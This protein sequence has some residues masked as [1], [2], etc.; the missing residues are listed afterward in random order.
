MKD[1]ESAF[2]LALNR[3]PQLGCIKQRQ[4]LHSLSSASQVFSADTPTLKACGLTAQQIAYIRQPDWRRVEADLAWLERPEHHLLTINDTAYPTLLK[5]IAD[6]PIIL[7]AQGLLEVLQTIQVG[8]IGSRNPNAG[9]RRI[10]EQF[11]RELAQAGATI[12]SGLALGIDTCSHQGALQAKGYTVAVAGN[13]LDLVYPARNKI[14][15]ENIAENGVLISEFPPGTKPI[16]ANFPRRNR[17]ISGISTGVLVVQATLHSGSLIT[18]RCAVEQ[19]REVFAV[20]GNIHD[21]L[22]KGCHALIKQGAKLVE[23]PS[24]ILEEIT[25]LASV[26]EKNITRTTE[27]EELP[28]KYQLLLDKMAYD[29][30]SI[31]SLVELT[32]L[33]TE[34]IS[35]MLS[36]LELRGVVALQAG[37]VYQRVNS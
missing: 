30:V 5:E 12:T 9:G 1:D 29:P 3:T 16:P 32:G 36:F 18:A 33:T 23:S 6:P 7:F 4:L 25:A 27:T 21:P 28:G 11:A 35:S 24:D 26:V 34:S 17:I 10:A 37:G 15:A 19:G 22:I 20:P 31:D 14:L 2:W 13:G 8:V